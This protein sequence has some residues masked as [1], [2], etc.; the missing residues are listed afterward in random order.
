MVLTLKEQRHLVH[1]NV[2]ELARMSGVSAG[3]IRR[4]ERG[5]FKQINQDT[6]R[7]I[8]NALK[9]HPHDVSQF[10][11]QVHPVLEADRI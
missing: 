11:A 1:L 6:V 3:T 8:C 5:D 9:V 2:E 4:I 10:M 7:K